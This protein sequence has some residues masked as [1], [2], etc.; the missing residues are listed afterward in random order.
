MTIF[1]YVRYTI[2]NRGLLSMGILMDCLLKINRY[3]TE[4][5][6]WGPRGEGHAHVSGL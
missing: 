6:S 3:Q 4:F 1:R 2:D 5:F